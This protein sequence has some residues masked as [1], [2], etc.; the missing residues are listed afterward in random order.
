MNDVELVRGWLECRSDKVKAA[1]ERIVCDPNPN[2]RLKMWE[3]IVVLGIVV[4]ILAV[5]GWIGW[6]F[7]G[8]FDFW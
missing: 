7:R 3:W 4:V 1:Y 8:R 5:G 6:W 2:R